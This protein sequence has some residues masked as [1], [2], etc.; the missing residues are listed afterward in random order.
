MHP[1]VPTHLPVLAKHLARRLNQFD[2]VVG[3]RVVGGGDADAGDLLSLK[4]TGCHQ[5][6]APAAGGCRAWW[7]GG[8]KQ[9][10]AIWSARPHLNM[11]ECSRSATARK[12]A[13]P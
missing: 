3:R 1:L 12:P 4:G 10:H 13:V 7:L 9:G 2:A 5:D 6:A 8:A 11:V